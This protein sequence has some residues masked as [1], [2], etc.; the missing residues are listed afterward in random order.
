[1][2]QETI[3]IQTRRLKAQI[4]VANYIANYRRSDYF[5]SLCCE[6]KN[7]GC[8]YGCPPFEYDV[9]D[10]IKDYATAK[11]I[12]IQI[13]PKQANLPLSSAQKIMHPYIK[14][15]RD[16]LLQMEKQSGGL[17]FGFAGGCD[18][19]GERPCARLTS[20]PCRH[21]DK[22]RPSLE[23]YGFDLSK[24]AQDL[25][26]VPLVWGKNNTLPPYLMLIGALFE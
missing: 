17:S 1:M 14:Q 15:L 20:E 11:I 21:P 7:Y 3:N 8:R 9:V 16:E 23:A 19:C 25:F 26:H 4:P 12:G 22:V 2:S 5:L 10:K 13:I 18:L 6:C 24:T